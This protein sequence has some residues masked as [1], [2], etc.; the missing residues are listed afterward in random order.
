MHTLT[1]DLASSN[2]NDVEIHDLPPLLARSNWTFYLDNVPQMD[3]RG[4]SCTSKWLGTLPD[5]EAAIINVR[6]DGYVGSIRRFDTADDEAGDQAAD[7]LTD[8][9]GGFLK[10]P[11]TISK[12]RGDMESLCLGPLRKS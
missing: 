5:N 3:T 8:Y 12:L 4:K 9:Y 2:K 10:V 6:P 1:L 11:D 7:W